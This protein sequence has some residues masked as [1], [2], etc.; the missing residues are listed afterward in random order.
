M[1]IYNLVRKTSKWIIDEQSHGEKNDY[2][3]KCSYC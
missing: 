2:P 3:F 1:S